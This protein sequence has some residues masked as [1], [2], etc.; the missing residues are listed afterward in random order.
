MRSPFK[1]DL[2][3]TIL[4]GDIFEDKMLHDKTINIVSSIDKVRYLHDFDVQVS[5]DTY[6]FIGQNYKENISDF[7]TINRNTDHVQ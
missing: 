7:E 6:R 2:F 4:I 1:N 3:M 5:M